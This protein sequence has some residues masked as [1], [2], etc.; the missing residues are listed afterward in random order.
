[1]KTFRTLQAA[2]P[3]AFT[4]LVACKGNVGERASATGAASAPAAPFPEAKSSA[5]PPVAP[6]AAASTDGRGRVHARRWGGL[7]SMMLQSAKDLELKEPQ[8]ETIDKLSTQV[9]SEPTAASATRDYHKALIAGI[10][11]GKVDMAKLTP[12]E[13]AMD[14]EMATRRE[15]EAVVLNAL[16]G[17][18][19]APQRKAVVASMRAWES[20]HES[21]MPPAPTAQQR[22]DQLT[23]DLGLDSTQ[24]KS[25]LAILAKEMPPTHATMREEM[26]KRMNSILSAFDGDTF[27]ARKYEQAPVAGKKG[28][29]P[30]VQHAQFTSQLVPLL[31]PEQR[32]KLAAKME[33]SRGGFET[34]PDT[35]EEIEQEQGAPRP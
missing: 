19:D 35:Q 31:R 9:R 7:A 12:L 34:G 26:K 3:I 16:H 11:S 22:V 10:R 28:V 8:R 24:Q 2:V 15:Q 27:D 18:L 29:S 6:S 30:M 17:V 20:E 21:R 14:R 13:T 33:K 5:S 23:T 1:M 25:V 32:E 4:L